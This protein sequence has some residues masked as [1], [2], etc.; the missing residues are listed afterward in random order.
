MAEPVKRG[1]LTPKQKAA[2][3]GGLALALAA[4]VSILQVWEGK[5]NTPH[6]DRYG[7]VWDVCYGETRVE[8]RPYSDYEC[9]TLLNT[10]AGSFQADVLRL[11]PRLKTDPY[12]LGAHTSFAYNLGVGTYANSSVRRLYAAGQEVPACKAIAKYRYA[13]KQV[14]RGL[15]L[16]R[17]GDKTRLGEIELCL[18]PDPGLGK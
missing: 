12:Q 14:L 1:E 16:R 11:N 6:W 2:T 10:A 9:A 3:G 17:L 7:K 5:V 8:M 15:E 4:T 18:T 13:G